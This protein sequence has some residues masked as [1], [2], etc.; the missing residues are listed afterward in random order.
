MF[1]IIFA[2]DAFFFSERAFG[3]PYCSDAGFGVTRSW[4]NLE[5][6]AFYAT[7]GASFFFILLSDL[8][9]KK[10]GLIFLEK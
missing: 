7:F 3:S 6:F 8:F 5:I 4:L 9:L 2:Q 10:T 1:A